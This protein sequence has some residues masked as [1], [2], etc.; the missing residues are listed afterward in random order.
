[1]TPKEKLIW[2]AENAKE[3]FSN[4]ETYGRACIWMTLDD[5]ES[6]RGVL[7][8]DPRLSQAEIERRN[9]GFEVKQWVG[10]EWWHLPCNG[11]IYRDGWLL[12]RKATETDDAIIFPD[13]CSCGHPYSERYTLKDTKPGD[14]VAFCWCGFCRTRLNIFAGN[15]YEQIKSLDPVDLAKASLGVSTPEDPIDKPKSIKIKA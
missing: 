6:L 5:R 4:I 2:L 1:M 9:P 3:D 14:P 10:R 15:I 8:A 11:D 13:R 12:S 7:N